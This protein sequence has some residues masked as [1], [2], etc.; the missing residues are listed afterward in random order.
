MHAYLLIG[1]NKKA[2]E[3]KVENLLDE[4]K[5]S[6]LNFTLQKIED[7]RELSRFV[8][9]SLTQKTA[10][11]IENFDS[12]TI[13]AQNAFLK[14]L[15]EPQTNLVYILTANSDS[16]VLP[17]II[18]RC[19]VVEIANSSSQLEASQEKEIQKFLEFSVGNKIKFTTTIKDRDKAISFCQNLLLFSYQ[20]KAWAT[21]KKA[22]ITL[23]NI[24]ANGNLQLHLT[25]LAIDINT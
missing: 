12:V 23:K 14:N 6:R 1:Q 2:K 18:S 7:V 25:N 19:Q 9:L 20:K 3:E 22:V 21:A 24:E 10:I 16:G 5:C 8:S 11:V 4:I 17:T 13:P 15:E